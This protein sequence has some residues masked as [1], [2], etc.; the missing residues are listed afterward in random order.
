MSTVEIYQRHARGEITIDEAVDA[1]I[2]ERMAEKSAVTRWLWRPLVTFDA[3]GATETTRG[4]AI[5]LIVLAALVVLLF[6]VAG[7]PAHL[8]PTPAPTAHPPPC[9]LR[10]PPADVAIARAV[11]GCPAQFAA[12]FTPEDAVALAGQLRELKEYARDAAAEC[13]VQVDR[14]SA[15][16]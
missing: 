11:V 13:G 10:A 16:N 5:R 9:H 1:L 7:C 8:P 14:A 12:C 2:R 4:E 6:A 15:K 3:G